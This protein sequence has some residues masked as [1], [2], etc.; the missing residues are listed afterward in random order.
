MASISEREIGKRVTIRLRDED[1]YRDLVGELIS[2]TS[3]LNRH[4]QVV[5]FDPAG[6]YI[7]KVIEPVPRTAASGAPLSMRVYELERVLN[8]TWRAKTEVE[9][10]GW[11][12]RADKGITRRANSALVL[13]DQEFIDE[14]I[15]W[16]RERD[17]SPTIQLVPNLHQ[18]LDEKLTSRGFS[19]QMD[20]LVM[21]KDAAP[22]SRPG[23]EFEVS[24]EPSNKWLAT[25]NDEAIAEILMRSKAKYL[26]IKDGENYLAVGRVGFSQDW[27]VLSRIWVEPSLRGTGLGRKILSA[28]E[29]ESSAP[30]IALQVATSNNVAIKLYE[31]VGYIH[32]HL[33]RFR[34]LPQ[35]INLLQDLCC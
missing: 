15:G 7:W 30:K 1:G 26:S 20:A 32:H 13:N 21:V 34:A 28:L 24:E 8:E 12:L 9:H 33:Y 10:N 5:S 25:Q 6:I 3:I 11:V 23:F 16:Y 17:L 35:K 4:G 27:A 29:Y 31:S 14:V 18:A 22:Q 2:T 19:D